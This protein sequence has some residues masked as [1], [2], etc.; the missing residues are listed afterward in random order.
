VR[1]AGF[2]VLSLVIAG[3]AIGCGSRVAER[4]ATLVY[5][6][7]AAFPDFDKTISTARPDGGHPTSLVQGDSP[8]ISP[9]GRLVV[10]ARWSNTPRFSNLFVI[11][12]AGGKTKLLEHLVGERVWV[13]EVAQWAPDSR[14]LALSES[15]GLVLLDAQ[16]G[17]RRVLVRQ[18]RPAA[19]IAGFSISPDGGA[20]V[21]AVNDTSGSDIY[22]I[23]TR[24]GRPRQITRDHEGF[25][26]LWGPHGIAFNRGGFVRGDIWIADRAGKHLRRVT[27]TGAGVYPAFWS[28]D[29]TRLLAANPATHNGR[30]WAVNAVTGSAHDLTGWRGDLF[31]QGLSRDGGTILAAIG[32]GGTTSAFGLIETLP[33]T[34]GAPH[35]IV[36][37]PC[38][39]SWNR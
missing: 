38:R 21:Y 26:P 36:R 9:D 16:T 33:F 7:P 35:V 37:G 17:S 34:G 27:H 24:G 18:P 6:Q 39:A 25:V 4:Q 19:G 31:P 12:T 3:V 14:H 28:A 15:E 23:S 2:T 30:L 22:V 11:P 13:N 10:F 29:G 32:C 20:I 8:Q 5:A 1:A